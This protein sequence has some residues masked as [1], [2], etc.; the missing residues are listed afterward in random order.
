MSPHRE[1]VLR[2]TVSSEHLV[3]L[4][5]EAD[6]LALSLAEFLHEAWKRGD[7]LLVVARPASWALTVPVLEARGCPV[8]DTIASGQ[9]V[10]LDAATTMA[11][12]IVNGELDHQRFQTA[13]GDLTAQLAAESKAGLSVYGEM[14]DLLVAQGNF[15]GAERLEGLWKEL[16]LTCSLRV[17]CG[18]TAAHFGDEST[19][20][21][22]RAICGLHDGSTARPTDLLSTW[23]LA[24]RRPRY[25]LDQE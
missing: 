25:H 18:Y 14:V 15:E 13:V 16:S 10:A 5:D 2:G 1:R 11:T 21:H 6:S 19:T 24:N 9:L 8:A 4:F 23:L 7:N 17:L 3:Q 20:N 22:L 12:F